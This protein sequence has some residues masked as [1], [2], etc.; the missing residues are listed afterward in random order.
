MVAEVALTNVPLRVVPSRKTRVS[1]AAAN[2]AMHKN[3]NAKIPLV[4]FTA[5]SSF[6][7][8]WSHQYA[9]EKDTLMQTEVN[10][11]ARTAGTQEFRPSRPLKDGVK[12]CQKQL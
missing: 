12:A 6:D 7:E 5:R 1:V 10:P 8:G 4:D 2:V 11:L 3:M 9:G